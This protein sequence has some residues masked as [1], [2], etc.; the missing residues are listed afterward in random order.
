MRARLS[1]LQ[2]LKAEWAIPLLVVLLEVLWAYPWLIWISG[3]RGLEWDQPPVSL[4]GAVALAVAVEVVTRFSLGRNWSLKLVRLF[5]LS[6]GTLLLAIV[7]RIE[8]SGGHALWDTGW[9]QYALDN[10]SLLFGGLAFGAYLIWRG[11]SVGREGLTFHDL[12]Q[13]FVIGLAALVILLV[14]WSTTSG[15][16]EMQRDN[17]ASAGLYAASYFFVGLLALALANLQSVREQMLLHDEVSRL[18]NRRWLSLLLGVVLA[19]VFVALGVASVFS[20]DLVALLFHPLNLLADWLLIAFFYGIV[21]PFALV[22]AG[23]VY[24]LQLLY[25]LIGPGAE[26]EPIE[27]PDLSDL[28]E[29][30]EGQEMGEGVGI[31]P[32]LV[33]ALKWG[34]VALVVLLVLFIL[35]RTLFRYWKGQA[36][37]EIEEVSESLWSWEGFKSDLRS[38]LASLLRRFKRQKPATPVVV[39]PPIAVAPGEDPGRLFTVQE[40]YQ[41]LLWE[42]RNMGLPRREPETPY[43]Y[44]GRLES[45]VE[46]EGPELQ[47][48]TRA[49]V[50]GRYGEEGVDS[51]QLGLL[52][53]LWRR[54]RSALQ[55]AEITT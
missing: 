20:V 2:G 53:R 22:G 6:A 18:F 42:G 13:R 34:L 44:Q 8:L 35:A 5:M 39:S 3:W 55:G 29:L 15:A 1:I 47:A 37:G 30:S 32:E 36:Q 43:E 7:V 54:L 10:L 51:E 16:G 52:N 33:L 41:G 48:I 23:V 38:F 21:L 19:I 9:G 26:P 31:S 17:L 45:R 28:T 24:G 46:V 25:H 40:I 4:G 12:Y 49:Y 50:A 11:I 14:L 27:P